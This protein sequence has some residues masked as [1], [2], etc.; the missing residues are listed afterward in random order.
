M[1]ADFAGMDK[2]G[3]GY[4]SMTELPQSDWARS[5]FTAVDSNNDGR[6]SRAEM[7]AHHAKLDPHAH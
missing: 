7:D 4:L 1:P 5:H 2:N 6:I 3:D